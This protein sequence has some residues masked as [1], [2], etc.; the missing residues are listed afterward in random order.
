MIEDRLRSCEVCGRLA[1]HTVWDAV[2]TT[3]PGKRRVPAEG[4]PHY[5]CDEHV[6]M[7]RIENRYSEVQ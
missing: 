1:K 7:P 6:R 2:E 3:H 5:F 4:S